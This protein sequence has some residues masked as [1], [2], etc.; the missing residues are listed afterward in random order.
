MKTD[1]LFYQLFKNFP[2]CFFELI[3]RHTSEADAYQFTSVEVKQLA[4]RIDGL[5]LPAADSPHQPIYFVEVQFQRDSRFYSRFFGEI[6]LYLR[7]YELPNDWR[8]VVVYAKRSIDTGVP[9]QY[10]GLLMSQQVQPV[11]LD[12]LG[13][14]ADRSLGVGVVKLIVETQHRVAESARQLID[15]A[16]QELANEA[17]R[18]K[19]IELIETIVLYKLPHLSREEIEAMFELSELKQTKYFQ[20]VKQEGLEEGRLEAKLEAVPQLLRFGLS[21]E[22]VAEALGLS[23]AQVRQAAP[24]QTSD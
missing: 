13:E 4:F 3:D 16:R 9:M 12:E 15:K 5:F 24:R 17:L 6:F 18:G 1:T 22:Q 11:Y 10:R 7:Q 20:E 19:V 14:V 21:V 23:I 8:A 2:S